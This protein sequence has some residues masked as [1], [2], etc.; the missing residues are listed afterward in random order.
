MAESTYKS[1]LWQAQEK[2]C[3]ILN[4]DPVLSGKVS[5]FSENAK[6]IDF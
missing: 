2:V 5:F 3:E 4:E 1:I 6:D